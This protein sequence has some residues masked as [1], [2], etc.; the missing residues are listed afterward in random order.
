MDQI[1][2]FNR[3]T[4]RIETEAIYG[5]APLRWVY[6][7]P[8]GR[9]A[10]HA[11]VKRAL[12]SRWYGWRM[13]RR[14]SRRKIQPFIDN[15][16]VDTG[17][18]AD[19]PETFRSFNEFFYRRLKP[20]ARPIAADENVAVLPAD[21]RHF[22]FQKVSD[23]EGIFVKGEVFK[24]DELLQD[25]E[26]TER[27]LHGSIVLSR[28]CPPRLSPVSLSGRGEP[29]PPATDRGPPV[30]RKPDRAEARYPH[31]RQEQAQPRDHSVPP[32]R[33]GDDAGGGSDQCGQFQI[34]L[35]AGQRRLQR[36]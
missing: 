20:E 7:N 22:G 5:E 21:G 28:L 13:N 36:E 34:H 29:F 30:L 10:L 24:L 4:G 31:P 16:Q 27:Y 33:P 23:M 9:L 12:F 32:V 3:Y 14:G 17:E 25:P 2:Y 15:Y 8:L 18:F 11:L 19:P 26:L 1:Q 35:R 6:G